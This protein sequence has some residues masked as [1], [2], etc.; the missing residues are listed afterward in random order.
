MTVIKMHNQNLSQFTA[1]LAGEIGTIK[2]FGSQDSL[3]LY[4]GMAT[5]TTAQVSIRV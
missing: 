5:W 3:A 1:E 2:R 4:L